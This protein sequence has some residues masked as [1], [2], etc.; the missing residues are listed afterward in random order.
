VT[1]DHPLAGVVT[2]HIEVDYTHRRYQYD[3]LPSIFNY[4]LYLACLTMYG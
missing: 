3:L 2:E 4:H 1:V